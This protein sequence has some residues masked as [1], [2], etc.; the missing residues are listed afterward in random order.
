[1][2]T[3][4]T[5]LL[6]SPDGRRLFAGT[7]TGEVQVWSLDRRE[8]VRRLCGQT[9]AVLRLQQDREGHILVA[10]HREQKAQI[11]LPLQVAVWSTADGKLQ[12]SFPAGVQYGY[13]VSPDGRWLGTAYNTQPLRLWSLTDPSQVK[14]AP[15]LGQAGNVAFSP[16]GDR[17]AGINRAGVVQVWEVPTLREVTTFQARAQGLFQLAF[18]PDGQRLATAGEGAEAIKL[19]DVATWE[20]LISLP[21]E[22]EQISQIF[23]SADGQQLAAANSQGDVL[24]RRVP[25]LAEIEAKE[26]NERM[27]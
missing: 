9:G 5:H 4:N 26:R 16:G 7:G 25:A 1:L 18:S 13:G 22:G 10:L 19:W 6:F 27:Q 24:W 2:G 23:F 8:P 3:N 21:L 17:L 14:T 11:G 15:C 20:E 12:R